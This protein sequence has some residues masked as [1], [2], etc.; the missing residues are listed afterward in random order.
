MNVSLKVLSTDECFITKV[1]S[2]TPQRSSATG[3]EECSR[4]LP[5]LAPAL[6]VPARSVAVHW[7]IFFVFVNV[8]GSDIICI[9]SVSTLLQASVLSVLRFR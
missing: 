8:C 1:L 6:T 9:T 5:T 4:S 3:T 2:T 7:M